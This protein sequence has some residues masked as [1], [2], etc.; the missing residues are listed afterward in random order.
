[1]KIQYHPDFKINKE[2]QR[3]SLESEIIDME[4]GFSPRWWQCPDC[5]SSHQR[6]HFGTIGSHRCLRCGYV[7]GDGIMATNRKELVKIS[8]YEHTHKH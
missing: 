4:A 5:G 8:K 1:M 6:G 7:G 3:E 2:I